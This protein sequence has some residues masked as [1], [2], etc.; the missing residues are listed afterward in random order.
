MTRIVIPTMRS[1]ERR[2]IYE[3]IANDV[4][5]LSFVYFEMFAYHRKKYDHAYGG[6]HPDDPVNQSVRP[7]VR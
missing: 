6:Q 5:R 3:M 7:S 1:A 2:S 4:Q